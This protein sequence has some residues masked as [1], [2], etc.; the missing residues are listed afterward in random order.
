MLVV[1]PLRL[2][3]NADAAAVLTALK[4]IDAM[5]EV[6]VLAAGYDLMARFRVRDHADLQRLLVEQVWPIPGIDR[7]ET[8]LAIGRLADPEPLQHVL[9]TETPARKRRRP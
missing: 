7:V 8:M 6:I 4:A 9:A 5:T 3:G 1:M 2:T